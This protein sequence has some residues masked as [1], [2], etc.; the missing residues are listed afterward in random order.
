VEPGLD[1]LLEALPSLRVLV[2]GHSTPI[3]WVHSS[4]LTDPAPFLEPGTMLL[5]TGTQF[6]DDDAIAPWV[7]RLVAAG[8]VAV[9]F[10]TE[11]VRTTPPALIDACRDA[12]L[13]LVEVPYAV[14]F[15]AVIRQVADALATRAR[16]RDTWSLA[17]QRALSVA[18]LG[19]GGLDNVLRTLAVRL[20]GTVVLFGGDGTVRRRYALRNLDPARLDALDGGARRLLRRGGRASGGG[21]D[22]EGFSVVHTIGRTES[23]RAA[24]G[25][26]APGPDDAAARA[27]ITSAVAIAEVT[28]DRDAEVARVG[29]D[30][31]ARVVSMLAEDRADAAVALAIAAGRPLPPR[32]LVALAR[33]GPGESGAVA[34]SLADAGRL[35]GVLD[36]RV[37]AVVPSDDPDLPAGATGI[38]ISAEAVTGDD[39]VPIPRSFRAALGQATLAAGRAEPGA[40]LRFRSDAGA[41]GIVL[42]AASTESARLLALETL[43]DVDPELLREAEVWL[44]ENGQWEP[45]ARRLGLHRHVLRKHIEGLGQSI[46]MDLG[47][48]G[49]RAELWALLIASGRAPD[50]FP[51]L[52]TSV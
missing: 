21:S 8:V 47:G 50:V 17:A 26:I 23:T 4:D 15:I 49:G 35:V 1:A 3:G 31:G 45:A 24:I 7:R 28:L 27:V 22:A 2:P 5:T 16:E 14:P 44:D 29:A 39:G 33:C 34:R 25:M 42:G 38:G 37:V 6:T 12:G 36:G 32:A 51:S 18:S 10:G 13:P 41:A 46:G 11:V 43:G 9:G 48:F 40:V 30:L 52:H 20:D 19:N